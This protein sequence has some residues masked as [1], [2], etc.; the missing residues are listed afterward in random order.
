[1][2]LVSLLTGRAVRP[3]LAMTGEV[4]LSGR[5]LPGGG[6]KEKVLAAHRAGVRTVIMPRRNEKSLLEDVPPAVREAMSFHLVD[7]IPQVL[8]AAFD[9]PVVLNERELLGQAG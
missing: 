9:E 8:D 7:S 5:V 3:A 6:I 4:S 2:A 1:T